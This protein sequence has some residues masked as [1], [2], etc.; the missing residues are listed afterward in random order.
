M[1]EPEALLLWQEIAGEHRVKLYQLG[2]FPKRV[3]V[4]SAPWMMENGQYMSLEEGNTRLT[5]K[6][7]N[8]IA[9]YRGTRDDLT[10]FWIGDLVY[11]DYQG[12]PDHI[13]RQ[14]LPGQGIGV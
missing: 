6:L 3:I 7:A 10:L 4:V 5:V 8:G 2:P 11:Q 14:R 1:S 13:E 12:V 9:V